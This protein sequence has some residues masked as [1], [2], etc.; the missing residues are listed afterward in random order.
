MA[1]TA[2]SPQ[3]RKQLAAQ[4][5]RRAR[6]LIEQKDYHPAV[7]MLREAIRFV[8]ESAEYRFALAQV[9]LKNSMWVARG[10]ENLKEAARL[11]P[12]RVQY[13]REAAAALHERGRSSEAEPFARRALDLDPT[14]E[15][16]H[17]L[18]AVLASIAG[19]PAPALE[20]AATPPLPGSEA[21]GVP[22]EAPLTLRE[23]DRPSL[24][25]RLFKPRS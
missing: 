23:D 6:S 24:F 16:R 15:N 17:L 11:E 20:E 10:L 18:D 1:E 7:E 4:N 19:A 2:S 12:R 5:Y 3:A 9:E 13:V 8:P 14:A 21:Q 22:A 25:S